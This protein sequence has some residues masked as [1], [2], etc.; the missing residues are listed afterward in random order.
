MTPSI[1]VHQQGNWSVVTVAGELD[2]STAPLLREQL[3]D[4][5]AA[6]SQQVAVD[7]SAVSFI[8]SVGLGVLVGALKRLRRCD[9]DLRV[10]APSDPVLRTLRISGLHRVFGAFPTVDEAI[11]ASGDAATVSQPAPVVPTTT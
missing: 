2:V 6:G 5:I 9:G 8:D 11:A 7:M 3:I 1:H 4:V 10:A